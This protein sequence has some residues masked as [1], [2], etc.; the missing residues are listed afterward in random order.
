MFMY[1]IKSVALFVLHKLRNNFRH[2]QI[3]G[4]KSYFLFEHLLHRAPYPHLRL[5]QTEDIGDGGSNVV[6]HHAF[7]KF[8]ALL[9]I[10]TGNDERGLHLIHGFA[11]MTFFDT[12]VVGS[13]DEDGFLQHAGVLNG[14]NDAAILSLLLFFF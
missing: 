10:F 11:A 8:T 4:Y 3:F 2:L 13:D 12:S 9:H 7:V 5:F 6:L 14:L 1:S